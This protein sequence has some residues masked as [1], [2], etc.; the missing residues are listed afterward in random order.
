MI[1]RNFR[2]VDFHH[3]TNRAPQ[4]LQF[5]NF[6]HPRN[7]R[8]NP[9]LKVQK[10]SPKVDQNWF[11]TGFELRAIPLICTLWT[12]FFK[13][14]QKLLKPKKSIVQNTKVQR[15]VVTPHILFAKS[16]YFPNERT[17]ERTNIPVLTVRTDVKSASR[18]NKHC[19]KLVL[20]ILAEFPM[21]SK[22][23]CSEDLGSSELGF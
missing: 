10:C 9:F 17:N 15:H 19:Y 22:T 23:L 4:I 5:L 18:K 21:A 20:Q 3:P 16:N 6:F 14:F 13:N 2:K 7:P 1:F 11:K 12:L 8:Q